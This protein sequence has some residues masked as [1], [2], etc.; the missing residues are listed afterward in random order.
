MMDARMVLTHLI[1]AGQIK[2]LLISTL[3]FDIAQF[4]SSL[5]HQLLLLILDKTGF[6]SKI[7]IFFQNYLVNKKTKYLW[8][9]FSFHFFNVNIGVGYYSLIT[10]ELIREGNLV[11]EL[12]QENS[13][14]SSVQ[15][16]LPYISQT[17]GLCTTILAYPK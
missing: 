8:N 1:H 6:D 12:I 9:N 5:N 14:E 10:L 4:F 11:L 3:V 15:D 17:T 7:V 16:H 2:H 13:I